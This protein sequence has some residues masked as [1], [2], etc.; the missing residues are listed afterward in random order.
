[1]QR[2]LLKSAARGRIAADRFEQLKKLKEQQWCLGGKIL[3]Q[4]VST[5]LAVNYKR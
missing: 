3:R 4:P 5:R 1:M 2:K